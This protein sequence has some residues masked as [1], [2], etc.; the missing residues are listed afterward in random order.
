M[1]SALGTLA[2]LSIVASTDAFTLVSTSRSTTERLPLKQHSSTHVGPRRAG[3]RA[4]LGLMMSD[5]AAK[6]KLVGLIGATGGVGRLC[7]AALQEQ[8]LSVRAIVRNSGRAEGLL[9][10]SVEIVEADMCDP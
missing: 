3:G 5:A 2:V 9:P 6:P 10:S 8:G 4:R 1:M 7:C